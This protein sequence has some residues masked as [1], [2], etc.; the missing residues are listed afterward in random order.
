LLLDVS[1]AG[2]AIPR[3]YTEYGI[4]RHASAGMTAYPVFR[5]TPA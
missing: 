3:S 5:V 1:I 2:I 4:S